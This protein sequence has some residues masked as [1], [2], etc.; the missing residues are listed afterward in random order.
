MTTPDQLDNFSRRIPDGDNVIR[1]VC[2]ACGFIGYQNPK[3]VVG[4][5]VTADDG[6]LLLCRRAIEPRSGFWTIPAG[7]LELNETTEDG[8]RREAMEEACADISIDRV[9]A[10]YAITRLSQIQIIYRATMASPDYAAGPE[11]TEVGLFAWD[12]IPWDDIAFPSVHWALGQYRQTIGQSDFA[13]F[14]NPESA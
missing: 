12:E 11:S 9:L 1:D 6:R 14:G 7:Y 5:V 3:I 8:A 4:A 10:I 2:D 13:P